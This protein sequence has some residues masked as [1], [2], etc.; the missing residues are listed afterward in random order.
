M[1]QALALLRDL[2]VRLSYDARYQST[3][4]RSRLAGLF[5]PLLADII[6]EAAHAASLP[7]DHVERR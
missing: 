3:E 4:A 5:F 1:C 6:Q 7:H 2:L